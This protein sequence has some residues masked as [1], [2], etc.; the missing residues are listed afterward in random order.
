LLSFFAL[1]VIPPAMTLFV[2][3]C[4]DC[5]SNTRYWSINATATL[6]ISTLDLRH[7]YRRHVMHTDSSRP[8]NRSCLPD[9]TRQSMHFPQT[10]FPPGVSSPRSISFN[11]KPSLGTVA[12]SPRD[13][14]RRNHQ[15][16][17]LPQ[18]TPSSTRDMENPIK[19]RPLDDPHAVMRSLLFSKTST[20]DPR[21]C[22]VSFPF[23]VQCPR[24]SVQYS[25]STSPS[26][27]V[28]VAS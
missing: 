4:F 20:L 10:A 8:T 22:I 17:T 18:P 21:H 27:H 12:L 16:E 6:H 7:R 11:P 9:P 19:A 26:R 1:S 23:H 15:N 5:P 14:A 2:L 24:R 3:Y 28:P 13:H 25:P